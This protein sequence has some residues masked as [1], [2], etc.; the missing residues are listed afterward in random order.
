MRQMTTLFLLAGLL[1]SLGMSGLWL[2]YRRKGNAGI[3]DAGWAFEVA[4]LAVLFSWLGKG[5]AMRRAA[6]AIVMAVWGIRLAAYLLRDRVIG[7]PEDERYAN[8]RRS[9]GARQSVRFFWFFQAQAV[10][11][12]FFALPAA[13]ASTNPES[14][15]LPVEIVALGLWLAAFAGE[16]AADRQLER[17]RANRSN[18]G[19]TCRDGL[20]RYSRHPNYFFEWMMWVAYALFALGSRW[21]V[22]ALACPAAM[23][24]LLFKV[25]GIP[26]TEAQA[27]RTRDGDYRDYQNT[28]S[29]FVPWFPKQS[30][31]GRRGV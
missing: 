15:W 30:P 14:R 20:W 9:W 22:L 5:W 1:A 8:L 23:L 3:V 28:T 21:G 11:A 4:T 29:A 19:R 7:R 6:V 2:F 12:L 10:A 24:Y 16:T 31:R 26:A 18:R 25:T 27:V 17:F 13:I